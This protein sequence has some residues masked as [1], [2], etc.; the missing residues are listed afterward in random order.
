MHHL[1]RNLNKKKLCVVVIAIATAA[2]LPLQVQHLNWCGAVLICAAQPPA[3]FFRDRESPWAT[4]SSHCYCL[5]R[6]A[7]TPF[8]FSVSLSLPLL[9]HSLSVFVPLGPVVQLKP[10]LTQ[11]NQIGFHLQRATSCVHGAAVLS[12]STRNKRRFSPRH[13]C[14]YCCLWVIALLHNTFFSDN[15]TTHWSRWHVFA[16]TAA[17]N[18]APVFSRFV[19]FFFF[20]KL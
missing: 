4:F 9:L 10:S 13:R 15:S 6:W 1:I 5:P 7:W 12:V 17:I 3:V 2:L 11:R 8:F 20:S 19:F 18:P 14:D 16:F